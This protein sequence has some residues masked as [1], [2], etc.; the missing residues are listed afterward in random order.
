MSTHTR[1]ACYFG[2]GLVRY[3]PLHAS[4]PALLAALKEAKDLIERLP[5]PGNWG[6]MA[7][8]CVAEQILPAITAAEGGTNGK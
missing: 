8:A 3:C 4:A 2:D 7:G 5:A 1:C 6:I